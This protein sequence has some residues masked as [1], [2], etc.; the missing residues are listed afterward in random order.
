MGLL[1]SRLTP[2]SYSVTFSYSVTDESLIGLDIQDLTV[3]GADI[4]SVA[5]SSNINWTT[6]SSSHS[7]SLI[8]FSSVYFNGISIG[9][10]VEVTFNIDLL[11]P[12]KTVFF[13]FGNTRINDSVTLDQALIGC[14][15]ESLPPGSDVLDTSVLSFAPT[16]LSGTHSSSFSLDSQDSQLSIDSS[17]ASEAISEFEFTATDSNNNVLNLNILNIDGND[18]PTSSEVT[19]SAITEDS[20]GYTITTSALLVN[21]SDVEGDTLTVSDLAISSG[22]GTLD[23]NG[24]GS[25][26]YTPAS[27][28]ASSVSFSYTITDDGSTDG[29]ADSQS[30][31]GTA[32]LD[33][34]PVN[35]VPNGVLSISGS[36]V[37]DQTLIATTASISDPDG[38]GSFNYQWYAGN[39]AIVDANSSTFVL[40]QSQVGETISVDINYID[41]AGFSESL[42][43]APTLA[44]TNINDLPLGEIAILGEAKADETLSVDVSNLTDEDGLGELHYQWYIDGTAVTDGDNSSFTLS[45]DEIGS[46]ISVDV[47]YVDLQG[48]SESISSSPTEPVVERTATD[49]SMSFINRSGDSMSGVSGLMHEVSADQQIFIR[50]VQLGASSDF[51]LVLRPTTTIN[52]L[53][54]FIEDSNSLGEVVLTTAISNWTNDVDTSTANVFG[55]VGFGAIDDSQAI[56]ANEETVI[57]RFTTSG[58]THKAIEIALTD[59]S[60]GDQVLADRTIT[61]DSALVDNSSITFTPEDNSIVWLDGLLSYSRTSRAINAQDALEAFRLALNQSTT[62]GSKTAQDY[63]SADFDRNGSVSTNDALEI[64]SYALRRPNYDAEWVFIDTEADLSRIGRR[65]SSYDTGKLLTDMDAAESAVLMGILLGDVN[66]SFNY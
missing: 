43:S 50:P 59:V 13:Y 49:L 11:E 45:V 3:I 65:S 46:V 33:I 41:A 53:N 42:V 40:T 58:D 27:D 14:I 16:Q 57:A 2:S 28:D 7:S 64:L 17:V 4:D 15:E 29:V 39:V 62:S 20:G 47:S 22:S 66:D 31:A 9:D 32:V 37:E 35:D 5:I 25:W 21:A 61:F 34:T 54:F 36:A 52:A 24:D 6:Q 60:L 51:E 56:M 1:F 19:L 63:I 44:V 18:A 10:T 12:V 48:T 23:D 26:L 38:L 55:F 30:I 8:N